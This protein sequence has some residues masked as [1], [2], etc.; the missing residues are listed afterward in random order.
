MDVQPPV[1][2]LKAGASTETAWEGKNKLSFKLDIS[3]LD[4][5]LG[6]QDSF[7]PM[8][9]MNKIGDSPFSQVW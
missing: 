6:G 1:V 8:E 9:E 7:N 5:N 3:S 4:I 2:E